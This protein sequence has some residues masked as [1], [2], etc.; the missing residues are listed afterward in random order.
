MPWSTVVP[1]IGDCIQTRP[2][3]AGLP[4]G[5]S[6]LTAI[7][8][9]K[10]ARPERRRGLVRV[11]AEHV[12]H[13]DLPGRPVGHDDRHE[14]T[15]A[16]R[17]AGARLLAHHDALGHLAARR[18]A[19]PHLVARVPEHPRRRR[20][21]SARRRR[22]AARGPDRCGPGWS[23]WSMPCPPPG[24]GNA[25]T[26]VSASAVPANRCQ[27]CAGH[28]PPVTVMRVRGGRISISSGGNPTH[29]A[30]DE[31]GRVAHEPG[32]G[33]AVA[34]AGLARHRPADARVHAR[35]AVHDLLQHAVDRARRRLRQD[36][37]AGDRR[38]GRGPCRR[39]S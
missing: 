3:R 1:A 37:R 20:A 11:G 23:S 39:S 32:V 24:S 26:G 2:A 16:G 33:P 22:R 28:E 35:P 13:R 15:G 25:E 17:G 10:P 5:G 7:D 29:T 27:I 12:R 38:A 30:V 6:A 9:P 4:G 21:R 19:Q 14:R 36:P 34:G 31:L 8:T 18:V